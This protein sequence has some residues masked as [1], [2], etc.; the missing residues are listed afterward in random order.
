M[1]ANT[2][3]RPLTAL[4]KARLALGAII[5]VAAV[6]LTMTDSIEYRSAAGYVA[7]GAALVSEVQAMSVLD[8]RIDDDPN[9]TS[10]HQQVSISGLGS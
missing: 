4:E 1:E 5:P 2:Q 3:H 8:R 10:Q 6:T 9:K 7:L